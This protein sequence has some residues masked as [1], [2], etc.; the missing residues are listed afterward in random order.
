MLGKC[1]ATEGHR[2]PGTV[3]SSISP[4]SVL[5]NGKQGRAQKC[6]DMPTTFK[7]VQFCELRLHLSLECAI[8]SAGSYN[9]HF[10]GTLITAVFIE[11]LLHT[12]Y[13]IIS[14][15]ASVLFVTS[16]SVRNKL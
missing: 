10:Q 2:R 6:P 16:R 8:F 1:S 12:R 15:S 3:F 13:Y 9:A 7:M 4:R 11:L 5:G 14:P